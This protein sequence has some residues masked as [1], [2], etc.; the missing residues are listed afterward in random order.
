MSDQVLLGC[1]LRGYR[2]AANLTQEELAERAGLSV[3]AISMLERGGRRAPRTNT[4]EALAGALQLDAVE[5]KTLIAAARGRP[6]PVAHLDLRG[7][8]ALSGGSDV[9]APTAPVSRRGLL[10]RWRLVLALVRMLV[11]MLPILLI[12]TAV[13]VWRPAAAPSAYSP[14][15]SLPR[16]TTAGHPKSCWAAITDASIDHSGPCRD[17]VPLYVRG[18]GYACLARGELVEITCYY[19]GKPNADG[20]PFQ[21][22]VVEEDSGRLQYVG[23]IPDHFVD[24][25][26]N[27]PPAVGIPRCSSPSA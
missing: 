8:E 15:L 24:L 5:R 19:R 13:W 17:T 2:A 23:H 7:D 26:S 20:D 11:T 18:G 6:E 22:H 16:C 25:G 27:P 10:D 9:I 12:I 21:V 4:L 1:V 3:D 14:S